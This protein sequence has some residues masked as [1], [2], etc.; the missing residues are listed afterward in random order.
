MA[1]SG[2][3]TCSGRSDVE[4]VVKLFV[5]DGMGN[6]IQ[7]DANGNVL[8]DGD[9]LLA[10]Y[11]HTGA[12]GSTVIADSTGAT[13]TPGYIYHAYGTAP[14]GYGYLGDGVMFTVNGKSFT[15]I[16]SGIVANGL[17]LTLYFEPSTYELTYVTGDPTDPDAG[18]WVGA[19]DSSPATQYGYEFA[20]PK[21]ETL[22][23]VTRTGYELLGWTT[24]ATYSVRADGTIVAA[25]TD[26]LDVKEVVNA[27]GQEAIDLATWLAAQITGTYYAAGDTFKMPANDVNL[28]AVWHADA[29]QLLRLSLQRRRRRF[30]QP[31]RHHHAHGPDAYARRGDRCRQ[32]GR[33][34]ELHPG[35]PDHRQRDRDAGRSRGHQALLRSPRPTPSTRSSTGATPVPASSSS[36]TSSW[37]M[38]AS[39]TY[40]RSFDG[41]ANT[42]IY[43]DRDGVNEGI[44]FYNN[45]VIGERPD[46]GLRV[47]RDLQ[48]DH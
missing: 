7:V 12:V 24:L 45:C 28:Y 16:A 29:H 9:A 23:V 35:R 19:G 1:S 34:P 46:Y 30:D 32:G 33:R 11:K 6:L 3:S 10:G 2:S 22:A 17:E 43:V 14:K 13:A 26:G 48:R 8:A 39:S 37:A 20:L 31:D 27:R 40:T 44:N 41:Y 47:R 38:T 36:S 15:S 5:V 4:Y 25:G 21:N 42:R 18:K